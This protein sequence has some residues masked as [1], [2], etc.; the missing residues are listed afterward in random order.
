MKRRASLLPLSACKQNPLLAESSGFVSLSNGSFQ[1]HV[2]NFTMSDIV[3]GF[4]RFSV[5]KPLME[6]PAWALGRSY[7]DLR[8]GLV[9]RPLCIVATRPKR[10]REARARAS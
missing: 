2:R 1:E 5:R 9:G 4:G 10:Q 7:G 6:E 3:K 8:F